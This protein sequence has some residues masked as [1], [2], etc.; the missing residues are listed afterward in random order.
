MNKFLLIA[1]DIHSDEESFSV[2]AE[3]A[4]QKDCTAFLYA[5]DLDLEN[6][7]INVLLS[8]RNYA[9]LPVIGNC[10]SRWMYT[11][12]GMQDVP[13]YRN[14]TYNG[15]M[16][17][18]SHGHLEVPYNDADIIITGHTHQTRLEKIDNTVFLNPGSPSRPRGLSEKSFATIEFLEDKAIVSTRKLSSKA[19]IS[20]LEIGIKQEV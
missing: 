6:P 19:V 16:I 20:C 3:I 12:M 10:D 8:N 1:S 9:F 15:L 17:S 7:L 18:L 2:L 4:E 5:G 14:C 13:L 11:S